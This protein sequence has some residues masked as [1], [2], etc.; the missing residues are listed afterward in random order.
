AQARGLETWFA[1][2]GA[3]EAVDPAWPLRPDLPA[4]A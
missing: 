4:A 3:R 1:R 2:N